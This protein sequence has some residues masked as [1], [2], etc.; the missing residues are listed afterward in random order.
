MQMPRG[1]NSRPAVC[2][3]QQ[4]AWHGDEMKGIEADQT[5]LFIWSKMEATGG[6][7]AEE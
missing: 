1:Q 4:G 2:W 6:I 3:Q 5:P 7:W